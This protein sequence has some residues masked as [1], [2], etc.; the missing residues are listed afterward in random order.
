MNT[1]RA[2]SD[3]KLLAMTYE[4]FVALDPRDRLHARA[5]SMGGPASSKLGEF[6]RRLDRERRDARWQFEDDLAEARGY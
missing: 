4:Q 2:F 3:S 5:Q 1:A 6:V